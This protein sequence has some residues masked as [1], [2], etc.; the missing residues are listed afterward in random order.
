M[1]TVRRLH[2][3]PLLQLLVGNGWKLLGEVSGKYPWKTLMQ[4]VESRLALLSPSSYMGLR[5]YGWSPSSH[6]G[7][8]IGLEDEATR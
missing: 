3:Q 5:H 7:S 2:S 6:F 1:Y 4:L 8:R